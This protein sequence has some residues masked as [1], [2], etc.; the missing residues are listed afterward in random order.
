[1]MASFHWTAFILSTRPVRIA[2]VKTPVPAAESQLIVNL[3]ASGF[4]P[5]RATGGTRITRL[6]NDGISHAGSERVPAN[7]PPRRVVLKVIPAKRVFRYFLNSGTP[8]TAQQ[9]IRMV[10]G[11]HA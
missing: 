2:A 3:A 8:Q 4:A 1:M 6:C 5:T 7:L 11:I 10:Q 9:M